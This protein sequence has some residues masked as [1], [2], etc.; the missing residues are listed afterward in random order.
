MARVTI[1][2]IAM[3]ASTV[4]ATVAAAQANLYGS[5]GSC[6]KNGLTIFKIQGGRSYDIEAMGISLPYKSK[7]GWSEF[8][9]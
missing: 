5:P 7:N 2:V 8:L 9:R 6:D 4:F 1:T 3:L